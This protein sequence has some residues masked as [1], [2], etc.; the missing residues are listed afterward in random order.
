MHGPCAVD[1]EESGHAES[2]KPRCLH[3]GV[4]V[5]LCRAHRSVRPCGAGRQS[6][7][8][9]CRRLCQFPDCFVRSDRAR[10]FGRCIRR[11]RSFVLYRARDDLR[12]RH[13]R[14]GVPRAGRHRVRPRL[15]RSANAQPVFKPHA[16][17]AAA[18]GRSQ[19]TRTASWS[20][21]A[22]IWAPSRV[23][24]GCRRHCLPASAVPISSDSNSD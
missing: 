1:R 18:M 3:D 20:T 8:A 22:A 2:C 16:R 11:Q 13:R 4:R 5:V 21:P 24:R 10:R 7:D 9:A 19:S 15:E 12:Q 14:A 6:N 23:R 17:C